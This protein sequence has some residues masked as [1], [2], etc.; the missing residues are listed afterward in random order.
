MNKKFKN[1][2]R[3]ESIRLKDF[4]YSKE[5]LYFI[6]ICT[7]ARE[8][9]FG[10]IDKGEMIL[11]DIG[12]IASEEWKKSE[13]IRK[14]IYLDEWVVMPNHIHGIVGIDYGD[15][16]IIPRRDVLSKRPYEGEH[17][18]MSKIAPVPN[19]LSTMIRFFKRMVTVRSKEMNLNFGWQARFYDHIIR[20][21]SSLNR[22]REYIVMNPE[23]WDRDRNNLIKG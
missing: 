16:L 10:N 13:T 18:H 2:Y 6:T 23:M 8:H 12:I 21:V 22:I 9:F 17:Q 19:S 7:K 20:D 15:D 14:Y 4:D 3:N 5:G 11:S 1:R